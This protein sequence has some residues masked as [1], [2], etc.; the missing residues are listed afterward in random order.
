[1]AE[2]LGTLREYARAGERDNAAVLAVWN[3]NELSKG[4][5][6]ARSSAWASIN[7]ML[8]EFIGC[9]PGCKRSFVVL[10]GKSNTWKGRVKAPAELDARAAEIHLRLQSAGLF[11][12]R[13]VG[14]YEAMVM[15]EDAWHMAGTVGNLE[16][17]A[18]WVVDLRAFLWTYHEMRTLPLVIWK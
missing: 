18:S 2:I 9:L 14:L 15:H 7:Q 3:F 4:K 6:T 5:E 13:G 10:A 11:A 1:M 17:W 12:S 16:R 8:P